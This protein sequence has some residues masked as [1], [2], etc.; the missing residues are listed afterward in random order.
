MA[1]LRHVQQEPRA[2]QTEPDGRQVLKKSEEAPGKATEQARHLTGRSQE[3]HK[4]ISPN[5]KRAIYHLP[6]D[7]YQA[8]REPVIFVVSD[9]E[10]GELRRKIPVHWS[11]R[12]VS[13]VTWVNERTVIAQGE[14]RY[15]AV[16]D[17]DNGE[18][19]HNLVG[20]NFT[21]SPDGTL[22]IYS[23]DF[24]PRYGRI[25]SEFQSDYVLLSSVS[26]ESSAA[27]VSDR[28]DSG[29]YRVVYPTT[30]AKGEV[31]RAAV[32]DPADR[33]QIKASFAWSEDSRRVAFVESQGEKLWLVVLDPV[34]SNSHITVKIRRFDLGDDDQRRLSVLWESDGNLIR[35][36]G[37]EISLLVNTQTGTI[38]PVP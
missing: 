1:T 38:L 22:I 35:V 27:R 18:Q 9:N 6:F 31:A 20:S 26:R 24:N 17:V 14:A 25:P 12:Y 21:L 13:S 16:I 37:G 10:R 4:S 34:L 23:H 19:T 7:P 15:L 28:F 30:L 5:R 33:H 29:D 3:Q 2:T 8:T 32:K 11:A 36:A